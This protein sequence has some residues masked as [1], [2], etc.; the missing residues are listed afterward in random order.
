M[1]GSSPAMTSKEVHMASFRRLRRA[2][3]LCGFLSALPAYAIVGGVPDQG[4]LSRATVMV[5]SSKGGM[6]SAVVVARDAVLTA[7]HCVTGASDHRVHFRGED[8]QPVLIPPKAKAVHPGYDSKAVEA[9]RRSIDLALLQLPEPLPARF[10]TAGL[11]P[12]A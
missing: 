3:T 12:G 11:S 2:A 9:R 10:Q 8:G 6:C 7:A 1:A 5:L 4:P